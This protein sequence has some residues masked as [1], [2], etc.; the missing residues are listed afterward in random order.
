MESLQIVPDLEQQGFR[1]EPYAVVMYQGPVVVGGMN[2]ATVE[3]NPAVMVGINTDDG[4]ILV[5]QTTLALFLTA[6]DALKAK[7]GD[8]RS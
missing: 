5:I 1:D 2:Q 3:G 4:A 7:Y 8:P 6:A